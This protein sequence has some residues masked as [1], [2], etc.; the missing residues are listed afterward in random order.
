MPRAPPGK[1]PAQ[2]LSDGAVGV[3]EALKIA[4]QI[5]EALEAAP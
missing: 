1:N 2:R 4:L 3:D 5:A